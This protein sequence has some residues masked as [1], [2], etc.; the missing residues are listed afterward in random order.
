V[1][2]IVGRPG[3]SGFLMHPQ[4]SLETN[5]FTRNLLFSAV[6][7]L[8]ILAPAYAVT[9]YVDFDAPGP[10]HD[11]TSW[12]TAYLTVQD[13]IAAATDGDEVWVAKGVYTGCLLYTSRCV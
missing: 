13:A 8:L 12:A 1:T 7:A 6:L 11:G 3:A 5:V 2:G 4:P 10:D 9:H